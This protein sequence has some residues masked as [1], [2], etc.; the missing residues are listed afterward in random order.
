MVLVYPDLSAVALSWDWLTLE[1][2]EGELVFSFDETQRTTED[3]SELSDSELETGLEITQRGSVLDP[4]IARFLLQVQPILVRGDYF[5]DDLRETRDGDFLS[6]LAHVDLF[7]ETQGAFSGSLLASETTETNIGSLG[8]RSENEVGNR[9]ATLR[10]EYPILPLQFSY[11]ERSLKQLFRS[12]L[13]GATSDRDE[14]LETFSISGN[15]SKMRLI[16]EHQS[17]DDRV[18]TRNQDY[19][20]DT[21]LWSHK[22]KWGSGS[23]LNSQLD[24]YDRTGFN[25][26]KRLTILENAMIRHTDNLRSSTSYRFSSVDQ[27]F[28][29]TEHHAE[30]RVMHSYLQNLTTTGQL[31]GLTRNSDLEDETQWHTGLDTAYRKRDLFGASVTANIGAAYQLTD[32][33]SE[34]GLLVVNDEPHTMPISGIVTLNK[35]FI[36]S[37]SIIV[38]DADSVVVFSEGF[39][40][41]IFSAVED[42][43][44]LI[45]IPGGRIGSGDRVLVSYR[46]SSLPSL[47]YSTVF[48]HYSLGFD[49][50][51]F[52]FLHQDN[53]SNDNLISGAG[54]SFLNDQR[55]TNTEIEF[56][57][58]VGRVSTRF[59]A[60][61]NFVRSGSFKT[62]TYTLRQ[63]LSYVPSPKLAVNLNFVESTFNTNGLD[64]DL[65]NLELSATWRPVSSLSIRPSLG[66]WQRTDEGLGVAGQERDDEFQTAGIRVRWAYRKVTMDFNYFRNQRI[67]DSRQTDEDRLMFNLRRRF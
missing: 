65:Y 55:F 60:E 16:L 44:Q 5:N 45:V 49:F 41:E 6:Y 61:R 51:W 64:T 22:L 40:Y 57:W 56:R 28:E 32:R 4:G 36:I 34:Q 31:S 1:P 27:D 47:E 14:N 50:G 23:I 48:T 15:T 29:S 21:G 26:W 63:Q 38:T 7:Q 37:G 19:K 17:L 43:T 3:L 2:L 35:R 59:G 30:T 42:L 8:S 12:G 18:E 25:A 58:D 13:S 24:F 67:I 52:R 62:T 54:E 20:L 33:V 39:D 53:R 10:W 9:A 46:A 66:A 11:R